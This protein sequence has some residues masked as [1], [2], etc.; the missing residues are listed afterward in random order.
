[1]TSNERSA[2]EEEI[3][4]TIEH[5]E[6]WA[7]ESGSEEEEE[8]EEEEEDYDEEE[9]EE[10]EEGAEEEK[11]VDG[12]RDR[13]N[14]QFIPRNGAYFLHDDRLQS[15]DDEEGETEGQAAEGVE[16]ATA[17][18]VQGT[19]KVEKVVPEEGTA[20]AKPVRIFH[21]HLFNVFIVA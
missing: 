18:I 9:E 11:S 8:E 19:E 10:E 1:M 6:D 5:V 7:A 16:G 12:D 13:R 17:K 14:P 4:S 21:L 15:E 3:L 20:D 2:A